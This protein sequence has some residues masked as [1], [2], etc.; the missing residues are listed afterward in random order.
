MNRIRIF[1]MGWCLFVAGSAM[2]QGNANADK[3]GDYDR[4]IAFFHQV[5]AALRQNE[6]KQVAQFIYFPL[7]ADIHGHL[8]I[9]H[10]RTEFAANYPAIFT[11]ARRKAIVE[12]RDSEVWWRDQGYSIRNGVIWFDDFMP[13][14]KAFPD[15]DT[16]EFWT[17]GTFGVET[18]NEAKEEAQ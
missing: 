6:P 10:T 8:R 1:M 16:P 2:G 3:R 4:A 9:I 12:S 14:G 18:V 17:S 11:A 7:R 5:Q 15:V 13:G